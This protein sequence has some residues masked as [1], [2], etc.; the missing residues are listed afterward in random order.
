V[1]VRSTQEVLRRE[2]VRLEK[3]EPYEQAVQASRLIESLTSY[4]IR[5]S[6]LRGA[7][8]RELVVDYDW[9]MAG[10][11]RELGLSRERVRQILDIRYPKNNT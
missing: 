2:R 8:L 3:L 7:A 1:S 9:S 11:G 5:F 6:D 10:L 4:R